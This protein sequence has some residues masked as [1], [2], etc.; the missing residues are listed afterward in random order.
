MDISILHYELKAMDVL[1]LQCELKAVDISNL[2]CELKAMDIYILQCEHKA[3]DV[4]FPHC[5]LKLNISTFKAWLYYHD[6]FYMCHYFYPSFFM[7]PVICSLVQ[8][9]KPSAGDILSAI[10]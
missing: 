4:S 10:L 2:Q 1:I 9:P 6:D 5:Q 7:S 3:M 8:V